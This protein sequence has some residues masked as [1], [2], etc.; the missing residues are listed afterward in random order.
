MSD[1]AAFCLE[2]GTDVEADENDECP[3]CGEETVPEIG[4]ATW[5]RTAAELARFRPW[6]DDLQAGCYINCVYCGHRYGPDDE[7][8]ATMA[9]VLKDHIAVCPEHPLSAAARRVAEL[10]EAL[11]DYPVNGSFSERSAWHGRARA[12]LGADHE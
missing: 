2:C 10:E 11:R 6:V 1:P 7:V 12:A 5:R 8:P 4:W 9:Q 3:R